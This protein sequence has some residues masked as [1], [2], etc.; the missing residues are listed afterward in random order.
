VHLV[1]QVIIEEAV[2]DIAAAREAER[3][4]AAPVTEAVVEG[5]L[6]ANPVSKLRRRLIN[7]TRIRP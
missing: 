7:E 2:L 4:V 3:G 6:R 1:G 5:I